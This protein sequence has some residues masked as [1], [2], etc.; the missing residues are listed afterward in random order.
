MGTIQDLVAECDGDAEKIR[1]AQSRITEA[2]QTAEALIDEL[3]SMGMDGGAVDHLQEVVRQLDEAMAQTNTMLESVGKAR[4]IAASAEYGLTG[5]GGSAAPPA[6]V[7][8]SNPPTAPLKED[9]TRETETP[10]DAKAGRP[11]GEELLQSSSRPKRRRRAAEA[12]RGAFNH[13][14]D[15]QDVVSN[16]AGQGIEVAESFKRLPDRPQETA[17]ETRHDPFHGQYI[18]PDTN[19]ASTSDIFGGLILSGVAVT[20]AIEHKIHK[21]RDRRGR[22]R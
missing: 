11:T 18:G 3:S 13:A 22:A 7:I 14:D 8:D 10:V 17:T 1:E 12:L 16:T 20:T 6:V 19:S 9:W 4:E 2:K 15:V 21:R 5:R